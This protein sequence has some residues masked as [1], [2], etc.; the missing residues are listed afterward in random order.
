MKFVDRFCN[1]EMF[2]WVLCL[3]C[4]GIMVYSILVAGFEQNAKLELDRQHA[5]AC[6]NA[7]MVVVKTEAGNRCV[8]L[9]HLKVIK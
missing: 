4:F 9:Q 1:M 8:E 6:Y 5:N 3:S 7:G 2:F